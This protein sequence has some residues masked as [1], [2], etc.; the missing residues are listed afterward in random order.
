M[1]SLETSRSYVSKV[2]ERTSLRWRSEMR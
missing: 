2:A 1:F